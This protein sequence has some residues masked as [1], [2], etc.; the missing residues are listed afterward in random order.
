M[1]PSIELAISKPFSHLASAGRIEFNLKMVGDAGI[2]DD[3]A[4][5]DV[6][7]M[8]RACM[9][10]ALRLAELCVAY[11]VPLIYAIDDDFES[12]DPNTPLGKYYLENRCWPRLLKICELAHMVWAFSSPLKKKLDIVSRHVVL[13]PAIASL[14]MIDLAKKEFWP[15]DVAGEIRIGYAASK[16]HIK[17]LDSISGALEEVLD[18]HENIY[19]ELI[20]IKSERFQG[21]PKVR[22][23][24]GRAGLQ[25]Y[26]RLVASRGWQ[27][28]LAPL[29]RDPANDAKTDNKYR[30]FSAFGI[31]A[32]Y[33][34]APPY[35]G[36]VI[37]SYNGLVAS[38]PDEWKVALSRLVERE[39]LRALLA[40][41]ARADVE[42]RY[43]MD[44]ICELYMDSFSALTRDPVKVVVVAPEI[45]ST[46]IDI[47][48]PFKVLSEKRL[49]EWKKFDSAK[50]DEK[51]LADADALVIVRFHDDA[52]VALART[53]KFKYGLPIVYTWD[54]DFFALHEE[55]RARA[56]SK[57]APG[58]ESVD[59]LKAMLETVDYVKSSTVQLRDKARKYNERG[60]VA[61]YGFDFSQI[62]R[63]EGSREEN[64]PLSVGFFGDARRVG[65]LPGVVSAL[66]EIA[67]D[68][69]GTRIEFFGKS[70]FLNQIPGAVFHEQFESSDEAIR[71]LKGLGWDIG[72]A[73]LS[74]T[75]FNNAKLPTKYRDY[76]ACGI[77]GLYS[78][79]PAYS[80]VVE[81]GITGLLVG[82]DSHEAWSKAL[83]KLIG[84]PEERR[85]MAAQAHAHVKQ[86]LSLDCAVKAWG[87]VIDATLGMGQG[88]AINRRKSDRTRRAHEKISVLVER[89]KQLQAQL[90][91]MRRAASRLLDETRSSRAVPKSLGE[92]RALDL[93]A[94]LRER[95]GFRLRGVP[96]EL[97]GYKDNEQDMQSDP[98]A[99]LPEI[100]AIGEVSGF[101]VAE[102]ERL[103]LTTNLQNVSF[104]EYD[105]VEGDGNT[106]EIPVIS[107]IPGLEGVIGIELVT[108]H[109][110]IA[111]NTIIPIQ[112]ISSNNLASYPVESFS[113]RNGRWRIRLFA[114]SAKSPLYAVEVEGMQRKRLLHRIY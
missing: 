66:K 82:D 72:I 1:I 69:P 43:G 84:A 61:P 53:A 24:E 5:S 11:A 25:E 59:R 46:R 20:S 19:L 77:A 75:D 28:G 13:V 18:S 40:A 27:I 2:A 67:E 101:Q 47:D 109:G 98:G 85:L 87:D 3:I 9:P 74:G 103:A 7:V 17:D 97:R 113:S 36:S 56:N 68:F 63:Y 55:R 93:I 60:G 73:P 35:W 21:H 94:H 22:Q 31:P 106:I 65:E 78:D 96:Y 23:L 44:V 105:L 6:V 50:I 100:S 30:E 114:R 52:A 107:K 64:K 39:D 92:Y 111:C 37:D 80:G 86:T 45:P 49:V 58:A 99:S 70:P 14:D 57:G 79:V 62:E 54:D 29:L 34:D 38:T 41:R 4:T 71:Y 104:I 95:V 15:S 83:R 89:N 42:K 33:A 26:Y 108:P 51:H 76:S 112:D 88:E 8:M 16:Y 48:G 91:G 90:E 102:G 32:V 10:N 110:T 81:G 12:L